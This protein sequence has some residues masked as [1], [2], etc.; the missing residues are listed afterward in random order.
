MGVV[1]FLVRISHSPHAKIRYTLFRPLALLEL[2]W[3]HHRSSDL[4]RLKAVQVTRPL[5]SVPY[6]PHKSSMAM[7]LAEFLHYA[8]RVE[9]DSALLYAYVFNSVEWLDACS[10]RYSNFHLVFLLRLSHFLGFAPNLDN[11]TPQSYF[12]LEAGAFVDRQPQHHHFVPPSLA[13]KLPL[14][15]RMNYGTMHLFGFSGSER[16]RLLEFVN[17]YY[18]LH[19]PSFPVLKSLGVL[20]EVFDGRA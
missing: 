18:R 10:S 8:I 16:S 19:L 2:T 17:T 3:N 15:M 20:K 7:F 4:Q 5:L 11:A 6:D 14:L 1:S 13:V 9:V 12:D